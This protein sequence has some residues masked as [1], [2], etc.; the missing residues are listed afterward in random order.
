MPGG[1]RIPVAVSI[2]FDKLDATSL[3]ILLTVISEPE[4]LH[5]IHKKIY[6]NRGNE[7]IIEN[8]WREGETLR[9]S[10]VY[11]ISH[12]RAGVVT[13]SAQSILSGI[14]KQ[15]INE[16]AKLIIEAK[17]SPGGLLSKSSSRILNPNGSVEIH[18]LDLEGSY[19]NT[20]LGIIRINKKT[21]FYEEI[22]QNKS[23]LLSVDC[24]SVFLEI[25]DVGN[26]CIKDIHI[27][28]TNYLNTICSVLSLACR[29]PVRIYEIRYYI[30]SDASHPE[31]MLP[32]VQRFK[33]L[34][35]QERR[36]GEP[37]LASWNLDGDKFQKLANSLLSSGISNSVAKAILYLSLSRTKYLEEAYFL[38][39]M[40]LEFIVEEILRSHKIKTSI[41]SGPW[42]RIEKKLRNCIKEAADDNL[43]D[44]FQDILI[45][46]PELKRHSFTIKLLKAVN[47]LEVNT[48]GI[49]SKID[50]K[51]GLK[52]AA[53]I[54]NQLFHSGEVASFTDMHI[55][56]I[57]LQF[58][59]E[60]ILLKVLGW[61]QDDVF[62]WNDIELR[63]VNQS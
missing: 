14:G 42:K 63:N 45:K 28:F 36:K 51:K 4:N 1:E 8:A 30:I 21:E 5:D 17:L 20:D 31:L 57:R 2:T 33:L 11:G 58:L 26:K 49:W 27:A 34:E 48:D 6:E 7:I 46:L 22:I 62:E 10:E 50:F 16:N 3:D 43:A 44:Y 52:N 54:R 29:I 15:A 53:K 12:N 41:P 32:A 13:I 9:I 23:A 56:L 37:L 39:F 18:E 60:R 35:N 40:S 24:T 25:V 47:I 55:N 59:S 61:S 19:W 38:C